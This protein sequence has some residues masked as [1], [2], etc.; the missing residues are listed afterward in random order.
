MLVFLMNKY[1]PTKSDHDELPKSSERYGLSCSRLHGVC[2]SGFTMN[3][4]VG[5]KRYPCM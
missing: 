3:M 1:N 2:V 5:T 4:T